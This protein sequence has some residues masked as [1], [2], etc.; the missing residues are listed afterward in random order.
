MGAIDASHFEILKP[1]ENQES[2]INRKGYHSIL[3]QGICDH[4]K[5]LLMFSVVNLG[6]Y[7]MHDY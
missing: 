3:L 2:Y 6:H 7:M 5:N 4:K 1:S